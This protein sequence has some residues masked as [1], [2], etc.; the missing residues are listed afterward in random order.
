MRKIINEMHFRLANAAAMPLISFFATG[1]KRLDQVLYS[2]LWNRLKQKQTLH[3]HTFTLWYS[4]L[5]KGNPLFSNNADTFENSA[6]E[7]TYYML[8]FQRNA[9]KYT[10]QS[11]IGRR[12]YRRRAPLWVPPKESFWFMR[13]GR[14]I[15]LPN[16]CVLMVEDME[17][18]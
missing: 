12:P 4:E 7:G 8:L 9:I 10:C 1:A 14:S 13:V 16:V 11:T 15:P 2:K 18:I 5:R 17:F 6:F 3:T